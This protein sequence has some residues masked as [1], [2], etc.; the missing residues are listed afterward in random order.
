MD[1]RESLSIVLFSGTDDRLSAAAILIVG[2]A[3]MDRRVDILLQY[4]ALDAF[5]KQGIRKPRGA[6]SEA[7]LEGWEVL[8]RSAEEL[9][10]TH[11]SD[12]LRQAKDIGGVQI[13]ACSQSMDIFKLG[14][15]DLDPMVDGVQGVAAF[16]AAATGQVVFI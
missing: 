5:R 7:G 12:V 11:W 2:A 15:E 6:S 8:Q 9:G 16:W 10:T 13:H 3:A 1:D 4:W 14:M